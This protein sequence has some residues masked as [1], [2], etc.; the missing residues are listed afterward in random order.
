MEGDTAIVR[1]F[2][3]QC[4]GHDLK[5]HPQSIIQLFRALYRHIVPDNWVSP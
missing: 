1:K 5:Q 4:M 2:L 3:Y